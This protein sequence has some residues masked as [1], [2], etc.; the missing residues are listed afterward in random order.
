MKT[1]AL[2]EH[3]IDLYSPK[4]WHG[5]PTLP[6]LLSQINKQTYTSTATP[7]KRKEEFWDIKK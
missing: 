3:E 4:S 1:S 7:A 6:P 2:K 5:S